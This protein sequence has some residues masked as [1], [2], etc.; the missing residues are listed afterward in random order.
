MKTR[1]ELLLD[2][3][4]HRGLNSPIWGPEG[5]DSATNTSVSVQVRQTWRNG[6]Q[7]S[8]INTSHNITVPNRVSQATQTVHSPLRIRNPRDLNERVA[9]V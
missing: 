1:D 9:H 3:L 2:D 6:H 5:G 4:G 7:V 8:S